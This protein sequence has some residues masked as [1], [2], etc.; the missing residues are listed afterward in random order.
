MQHP[1]GLAHVIRQQGLG[2]R[3]AWGKWCYEKLEKKRE[4]GGEKARWKVTDTWCTN[5]LIRQGQ[6]HQFVADWIGNESVP[7]KRRRRIQQLELDNFPCGT[8]VHGKLDSQKSDRCSLCRKALRVEK[9]ANF[10]EWEVPRETVGHISSAGCKGQK[11][12]V[13]LAHNN[14]FR[15]L[16]FDIAR[17]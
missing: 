4:Q 1:A 17:V 16:M 15:D 9:G 6:S 5:F 8:W 12:V 13:T 3:V 2:D 14:V 7:M 11:E 10:C